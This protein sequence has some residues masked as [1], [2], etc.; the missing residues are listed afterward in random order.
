MKTQWIY[1]ARD[2]GERWEQKELFGSGGEK[3]VLVSVC[4]S[5]KKQ[6]ILGFG[7][8]FTDTA[9]MALGAMKEAV[10][11]KAVAAC[12]DS[13]TGL[14]YNMGRIPIG[15]CDFSSV[16]YSHAEV[17][18]DK[19]LFNYSIAQ[20]KK[21][22]V[23]FIHGVKKYRETKKNTEELLLYALPWSPPG[24]MKTNGQM[25]WGGKLLPQYYQTM[26][27]YLIKF[28]RAYEEEK[29]SLWGLAVQNEPIEV[30]R[31]AS[32]E[33]TGKEEALFLKEYLL[34]TLKKE[35]L[36]DI[37]LL[38]WDCNKDFLRERAEEILKDTVLREKVFGVAFHWY[39]GDYF[40]ELDKTHAEF[41]NTRLLATESCVVMPENLQ[42]W[43]VGERY[44]HDMIGDFNHWTCAYIDWNLFLNQDSG[45]GIADNPCAAPIILDDKKQEM[46][47]MSSYY[48]IGHFSRYVRR[49]A[50]SLNT[51]IH[52]EKGNRRYLESCSFLNP[53][54]QIAVIIMN[55]GEERIEGN[56]AIDGN[57]IF[58]RLD[59]HSI[60]TLLVNV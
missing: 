54:G 46:I 59:A 50:Y 40:E 48:Y 2:T 10:R 29:I 37:K 27:D 28:I 49:G 34:P 5:E 53:D 33:Y 22:I 31:W 44:G 9:A 4:S 15:C 58:V 20:D 32:C 17:P 16:T 11:K 43:S 21:G 52:E 60:G 42:D 38:C 51:R 24:W 47:L 26:A 57:R 41:P 8:A 12:F 14:G 35:A 56:I 6:R 7:G 1:T 3:P 25:S 13:E 19:E 45:P 39:S 30:Q 36:E 23:P 18:E 55:P